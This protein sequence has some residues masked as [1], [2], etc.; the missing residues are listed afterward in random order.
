MIPINKIPTAIEIARRDGLQQLGK[1]IASYYSS[2][3]TSEVE[4]HLQMLQEQ[5]E[6]IIAE[7]GVWKGDNAQRLCE[8]LDIE[9]MYLIDP[10]NKY[11][12]WDFPHAHDNISQA[13]KEARKKLNDYEFITWLKDYS[14]DAAE[15]IEEE[16]DYVY[17][18]GN[19]SYDFVKSDLRNYYELLS[20]NG[21]IAG[22]DIHF[23]GV[24]LAVSEFAVEHNLQPHFEVSHPDWYFIKGK[25]PDPS[26][27]YIYTPENVYDTL[28]E[29]A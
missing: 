26:L 11:E 2:N 25:E 20:D 4:P 27:D 24:A 15:K 18:D 10:Y 28:S 3:P 7:I 19:H 21:I 5:E 12:D 16:L 1:S 23:S 17:V 14:D 6:L 29:K 13:E 22:D 9:K 8:I